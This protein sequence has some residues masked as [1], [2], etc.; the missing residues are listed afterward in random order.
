MVWPIFWK[1]RQIGDKADWEHFQHR[2][3]KMADAGTNRFLNGLLHRLCV[4]PLHHS[5]LPFFFIVVGLYNVYFIDSCYRPEIKQCM[6]PL[7]P[8]LHAV[9]FC[10]M[11]LHFY[12]YKVKQLMEIRKWNLIKK[13]DVHILLNDSECFIVLPTL[14]SVFDLTL[15]KLP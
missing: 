11:F 15:W 2:E 3:F 6:E 10:Y 8:S 13:L 5:P 7:P 1:L 4:S 9:F 14:L 12:C